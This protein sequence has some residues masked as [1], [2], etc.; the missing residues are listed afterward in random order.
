MTGTGARLS[1]VMDLLARAL[2]NGTLARRG[3]RVDAD[4]SPAGPLLYE[5]TAEGWAVI[6]A[7]RRL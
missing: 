1:D 6:E 5:L 2:S 3:H 4:G 7:D